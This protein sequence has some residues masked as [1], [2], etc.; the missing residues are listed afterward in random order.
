MRIPLG[1]LLTVGYS[2]ENCCNC[3]DFKTQV[4]AQKILDSTPGEPYKLD[5]ASD[6]VAYESL[7]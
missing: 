2:T 7:S 6:G 3:R 5:R 1:G 4:E